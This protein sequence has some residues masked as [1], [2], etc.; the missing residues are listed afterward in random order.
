MIVELFTLCEYATNS[1]GSLTI[2]NTLDKIV[3]GKLPWRAYFGFAIKGII[4][5]EQPQNTR[6]SLTVFKDEEDQNIF[7][8]TFPIID[9]IGR[10]AA[11]GN[12][13]GLI[14]EQEGI[15]V[16]KVASNNGLNIDYQFEVKIANEKNSTDDK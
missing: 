4:K 15:Y 5:H 12:L 6:L 9:K 11:A 16:F 10:F 13:R 8:T 7:E 2:V 1:N 3:V 14:F